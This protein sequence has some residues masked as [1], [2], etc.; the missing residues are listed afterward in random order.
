M[1][2]TT[3]RTQKRKTM[4]PKKAV[5]EVVE[6]QEVEA[7]EAAP[8]EEAPQKIVAAPLKERKKL[9]PVGIRKNLPGD[10]L[11]P[12]YVYRD[13]RDRDHRL[14]MFLDAGYEFV[15]GQ[16]SASI[17]SRRA[18]YSKDNNEKLVRMRIPKDLYEEYQAMKQE[19]VNALETDL[20]SS[21]EKGME[22]Q[23]LPDNKLEIQR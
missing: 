8:I 5:K 3:R 7:G 10:G 2:V 16:G 17:D 12:N 20:K 22:G 18:F 9:I 13:V 11:D 4:A 19:R 14:Q 1:A 15:D 23:G 6:V 21:A